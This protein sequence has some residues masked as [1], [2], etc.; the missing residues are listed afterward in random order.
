MP[1]S[2]IKVPPGGLVCHAP[3]DCVLYLQRST[4]FFSTWQAGPHRGRHWVLSPLWGAGLMLM[5]GA[6]LVTLLRGKSTD[7]RMKTP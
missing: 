6:V 1:T 4:N 7:G 2:D 5:T 3:S